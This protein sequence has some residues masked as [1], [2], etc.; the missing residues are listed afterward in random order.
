[1]LERLGKR[2]LIVGATER[3]RETGTRRGQR[4][5]PELFQSSRAAH[6][7]WVR[8]HETAGG[9]Q[10]LKRSDPIVRHV[11]AINPPVRTV[12]NLQ[13]PRPESL[14]DRCS[15]QAWLW[16]HYCD[17]VVGDGSRMSPEAAGSRK[18]SQPRGRVYDTADGINPEGRPCD[19]RWPKIYGTAPSTSVG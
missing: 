18:A 19:P 14:P 4:H 12:K 8:H 2:D 10:A 16:L 11:H 15:T 7:P 5:E 13:V 6:V 17:P 3:P 9:V 1:M